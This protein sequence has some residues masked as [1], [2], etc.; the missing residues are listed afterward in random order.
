MIK[1]SYDRYDMIVPQLCARWDI[2]SK[3]RDFLQAHELQIIYYHT[4]TKKKI[5][6]N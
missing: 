3:V 1:K 6:H 4:K 2:L 5:V